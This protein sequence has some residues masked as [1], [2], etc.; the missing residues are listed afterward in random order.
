[1]ASIINRGPYQFQ[2]FVR[3]KGYPTQTR[4]F[5]S[6]RE[7]KDWSRDVEAKMRRGEFADLSEAEATTLGE[8]LERYRQ[9]VTPEKRGHV[10]ENYRVLQLIRHPIS[11]RS[12]ASLRNV[13]FSDYRNERIKQVGPK[14]VQ[15]E[16]AL[17]SA[18]LNNARR[19]WSIPIENSVTDIRKP[20]LPRGRDRRLVGDEETRL[21][22]AAAECRS[23]GLDVCIRLALEMGM[24]RGEISNLRW[25]Q[26][27]FEQH[28]I[29]LDLTK[30]GEARV[31]PMSTTAEDAIRSLHT[32]TSMGRLFE[33]YD[34]DGLGKAYSRACKRAGIVGLR[35]HDLRHE[36]ASRWAK[37]VPVATLA[38]IF[39]WK[40]LQMAMRYY[41][42]TAE[43]LVAAVRDVDDRNPPPSV[44]SPQVN[45][46]RPKLTTVSVI[47]QMKTNLLSNNVI[48][49][50]FNQRSAV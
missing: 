16:L 47:P 30:N 14:T 35:F 41:N 5:E 38:K 20:K 25:S 48:E 24:R 27:D 49:V 46:T 40:T 6:Q 43:E 19:D 28:V 42:P 32:P 3:R 8:L 18:V 1:M 12:L 33:F 2:A 10:Q 31:V 17:L 21:F 23:E 45:H 11:L 34:S 29:R 39:G 37:K 7:A 44:S 13:D 22:E 9:E 4:T 50:Q 26:V 15:L 36:A